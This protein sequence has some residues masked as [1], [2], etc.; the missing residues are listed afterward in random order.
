MKLSEAKKQFL[1]GGL[2]EKIKHIYVC[3]DE[4]CENVAQRYADALDCFAA[5]YG[6]DRDIA[7]FSAPGRTEVGGNH[8]DHQHG[9]VLAAAV[10]LDVIAVVSRSD[11][12]TIRVKSQGYPEDA[13]DLTDL[14]VH[15]DEANTSQS[16]IRGLANWFVEKDYPVG[17]FDA[18]TTSQVLSGSGISS[19]A[20]FEVLIGTAMN[21]L[22]CGGEESPMR[23]A[24]AGQYAENVYFGKPSGLMDQA[25]SS[26]GGFVSIDFG[27]VE[28][29]KAEKVDFDLNSCGYTL[30]IIDTHA[31]HADLTSDYAA[32]P[33]ESRQVAAYFN[34][35]VL[36]DVPEPIFYQNIPQLREKLGDRPV[37]RAM[38]FYAEDRRAQEEAFALRHG[39]FERFKRLVRES[40]ASSFMYL[41]NIYSAEHWKRQAVSVTLGLIEH[42]ANRH[43]QRDAF[44]W[45]VHGGGFAGTVQAFVPQKWI[46]DFTES[47]NAWL[48]EGSCH[49][50]RVRPVGGVQ[51]L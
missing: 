35:K 48:G 41:Q 9:H 29:P 31:S 8:T 25:A 18:Y 47:M 22:F 1:M 42:F 23:I 19:S 4:E 33:Q 50:L 51:I 40:G 14:S 27:D 34:K 39:D 43:A 6:A 28:H 13:V 21:A 49:L 3:S 46:A 11:A 24:Q 17:G 36:H 20:A 30:C 26:I 7:V 5:L 16:L 38:H 32:I 10:N 45:R 12:P 44:A 15:K 2:H 37:L